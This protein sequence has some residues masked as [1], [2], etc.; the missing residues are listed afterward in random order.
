MCP[1]PASVKDKQG[2]KVKRRDFIRTVTA[3]V[4]GMS[5]LGASG[6]D[7]A[8]ANKTLRVALIGCGARACHALLPN[9]VNS[10]IAEIVA[11]VDPDGRAITNA[12]KRVKKFRPDAQV[13]SVAA[14]GDYRDFYTQMSGDVD[15]V[16][17]ATPNHQHCLP[18]L[19]AFRNGIH[20]YVEKPMAYTV[21]EG[22]RM[23]AEARTHKVVTQMGHHGHSNEGARRLCEYVWAGAIGQVKEVY[24]W[25][26]RLNARE[27][28]LPK[29]SACPKYLDWDKWIGPAAWRNFT[30]GLH[31]AGWYSWRGFGSATVGNMGNHVIDP[32]FWALKLGS[33]ESVQLADFLP[34]SEES[35]GLRDHIIW[36]FPKRGD[37]APVEMHWFDGLKDGL[38]FDDSTWTSGGVYKYIVKKENQNL[39][40]KLV[41]LEKKYNVDLGRC[42][43]ILIG[44]KGILCISVFGESLRFVPD[45]LRSSITPPPKTIPRIK[46]SH[47]LDFMRACQGGP[48]ACA[49]FDYSQPLNEI[50]LLGIAAIEEGSGK[51]LDWDGKTGRFTNDVAANKL[52][53]RPNRKG[54]DS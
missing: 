35:W 31:P 37:L 3:G 23:L 17:I 8:A 22:R 13:E 10:G 47:Q 52:L 50:M 21:E 53:S 33:P 14:F 27:Q 15:A 30:K 16:F 1:H 19:L 38:H 43:S 26:N 18:A 32:V 41:E 5:V 42:A 48:A 49:N 24:C 11:F 40:P 6:Q 44:E 9:I 34:G 2:V 45:S 20:A 7:K 28:P 46:G 36:K 4:G 39:P 51:Q 25:T 54:W 29:D 12:R